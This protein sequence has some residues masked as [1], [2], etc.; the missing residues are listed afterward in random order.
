[1]SIGQ[2]LKKYRTSK[3]LT[4]KDFSELSGTSK[5]MLSEIENDKKIPSIDIVLR[6]S[7]ALG[8]S[9]LNL[10]AEEQVKTNAVHTKAGEHLTL[11]D[12]TAGLDLQFISPYGKQSEQQFAI[13]TM[14]PNSKTRVYPPCF[15]NE[16]NYFYIIQGVLNVC[17]GE[18]TYRLSKGDS[19]YFKPDV[20]QQLFT[21]EFSECH[22][23][24]LKV[25]PSR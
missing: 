22:F 5:S 2:T 15:Q 20:E 6:I 21:E 1:M 19:L 9:V 11:N 12:P 14:P 4:L 3:G 24:V 25:Y 23:V 7:Q 13:G 10:I 16:S 8:I 18:M 17:L